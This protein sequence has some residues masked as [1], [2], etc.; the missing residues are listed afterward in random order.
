M[1]MFYLL[2][3]SDF[4][5]ST[6]GLQLVRVS[7]WDVSFPMKNRTDATQSTEVVLVKAAALLG[8]NFCRLVPQA[9]PDS[10]YHYRPACIHSLKPTVENKNVCATPPN[11]RGC[12]TNCT[13]REAN[14]ISSCCCLLVIL[15]VV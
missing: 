3:T 5:K 10:P 11:R 1:L 14:G 7:I 9:K 2:Y 6:I 12:H 13:E 8:I 15:L 4:P